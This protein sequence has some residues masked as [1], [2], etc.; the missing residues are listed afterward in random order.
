MQ[1]YLFTVKLDQVKLTQWKG[2]PM[3]QVQL[4]QS[5]SYRMMKIGMVLSREVLANF[6]RTYNSR[7]LNSMCMLLLYRFIMRKFMIC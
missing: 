2:I 6:I 5:L 1:L 7:K 3:P 4:H